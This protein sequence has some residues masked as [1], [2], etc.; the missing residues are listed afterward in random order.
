ME[1]MPM[2]I[3]IAKCSVLSHAPPNMK[4]NRFAQGE[5]IR[6]ITQRM[7]WVQSVVH[8]QG[9]SRRPRRPDCGR[10][11]APAPPRGAQAHTLQARP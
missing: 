9:R 5:S 1:Y 11:H 8:H 2:D 7:P 4:E 6:R 3:A 10:K